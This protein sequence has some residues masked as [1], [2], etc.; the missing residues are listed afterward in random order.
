MRYLAEIC[1]IK[2]IETITYKG[3]TYDKIK[4]YT[5]NENAYTFVSAGNFKPNDKVIFIGEGALIP[6]TNS[7]FEFLRK[8]CYSPKYKAFRIKPIRM[9]GEISVGLL[10]PMTLL[11]KD[12]NIGSDVTKELNIRKYEP[13]EDASPVNTNGKQ[14]FKKFVFNYF[15]WLARLLW[16]KSTGGTA[17][18]SWLISKTDE[19]NIEYVTDQLD[20]HG[21]A[22]YNASV[23]MERQSSTMFI[24]RNKL[25]CCS[26]NVAYYVKVDNNY[27]NVA[28]NLNIEKKLKTYNKIHNTNVAIQGEICGPGIQD[29]IYKF[30]KLMLFIF[31]VKDI[32]NNR[33]YSKEEIEEFCK[34]TGLTHVP[35]IRTGL[36]LSDFVNGKNLD[37]VRTNIIEKCFFKIHEPNELEFGFTDEKINNKDLFH[38][39]GLVIRTDSQSF[40]CKFKSKE[41][42]LWFSGKNL[43]Y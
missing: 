26:R 28:T 17:F 38:N 14:T 37:E 16:K 5:L 33:Y 11:N 3:Q 19:N 42:A 31:N 22:S 24:E 41:Y 34:E 8:T 23:K 25:V 32:K 29:N 13:S 2:N 7:N 40:S 9:A 21:N 43:E 12:Y 35:Y 20:Y 18:P 39:E 10:M 27:W 36:K 15:P 1:P 4:K 30:N 6:E